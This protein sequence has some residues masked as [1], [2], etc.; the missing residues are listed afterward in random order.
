MDTNNKPLVYTLAAMIVA[1]VFASYGIVIQKWVDWT[2]TTLVDLDKRT[3]IMET[4]MKH[5][6][7]MIAQNHQ[8]LKILMDKVTKVQYGNQSKSTDTTD[9]NWR[10]E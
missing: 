9:I 3:A 7:D 8:M 10:Q 1:G 5:T 2:S 4:E 6:N